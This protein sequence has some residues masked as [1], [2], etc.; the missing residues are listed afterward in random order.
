M[1]LPNQTDVADVG[2]YRYG[3]QG[4]EI[5]DE[6]KGEG[7]SIDFKF[8][9]YDTRIGKFLSL[10]PLAD[11]YPQNSPYAFAENRV[12]DGIELEGAEY[13][14]KDDALIQ[15]RNGNVMLR[16]ENVA[17]VT[18]NNIRNNNTYFKWNTGKEY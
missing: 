13:L 1:M 16:K 14:D 15:V 12:I 7:N 4:Q 18:Q 5:D 8:R 9:S 17:G 6:V 2:D 3:F 11:S 10:D